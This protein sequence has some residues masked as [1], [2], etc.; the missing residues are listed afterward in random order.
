[1]IPTYTWYSAPTG[2]LTF[3]NER[4]ANFL[5]LPEDD[6]LR[7]GIDV[8]GAWDSH[9][10][11]LHP[12]DHGSTRNV[13]ATC[14]RTGV[15]GKARFRARGADGAYRWFL[16]RAEPLRSSDGTLLYWIGVNLDID[17]AMQAEGTL[18][19]NE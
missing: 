18:T 16:S 9:I 4:T 3:V 7:F 12:D 10:P 11:L 6:P 17:D 5:G 13:W 1:M 14:L 15:A 19:P 8:G 2:A